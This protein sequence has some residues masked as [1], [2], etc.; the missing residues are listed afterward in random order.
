AVGLDF[1]NETSGIGG[2]VYFDKVQYDNGR[3]P[4]NPMLSV[5]EEFHRQMVK[6]AMTK[7]RVWKAEREHRMIFNL[8][9]LQKEEREQSGPQILD[10]FVHIR[11]ETIREVAMGCFILPRDERTI[12][13][14]I[15]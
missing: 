15:K 6:I 1:D 11:P 14:I 4:L 12:R 3:P 7:S 8:E 2:V 10:Y 5:G 13:A 9:A